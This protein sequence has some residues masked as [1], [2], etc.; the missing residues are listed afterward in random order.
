MLFW[1]GVLFTLTVPFILSIC[2]ESV[3]AGWLSA[4]CGAF[5]VFASKLERIAELSLG[6]VKAKMREKIEEASATIEQLRKVSVT[7][8]EAELTNL[9]ATAFMGNMTLEKKLEIHDKVID[10][11]K[12]INVSD[13]QISTAEESWKKGI[14]VIYHRA[15]RNALEERPHP[16]IVNAEISDSQK[17]A[18]RELQDLLDFDNWL[19][20][21]P[22]QIRKLLEKHGI[23]SSAAEVWIDDYE[24]FL[25]TNEIRNREEFVRQ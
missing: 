4:A 23:S 3:S 15:I 22:Y 17:N 10:E 14:T 20:P 25:K 11:L 8:A 13:E 7:I 12:N 5:V 18:G 21:T 24:H 2:F 16:S 6:P 1:I 19:P 9:I